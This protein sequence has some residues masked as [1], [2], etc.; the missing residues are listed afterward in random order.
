M[1]L[2]W[3]TTYDVVDKHTL[4]EVHSTAAGMM[5]NGKLIKHCTECGR[6]KSYQD[7]ADFCLTGKHD[8]GTEVKVLQDHIL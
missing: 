2:H 3:L 4:Q 7:W 8:M 5:M 1:R 6:W